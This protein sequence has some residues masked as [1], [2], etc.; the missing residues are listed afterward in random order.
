MVTTSIY[1]TEQTVLPWAQFSSQIREYLPYIND[2]IPIYFAH[3]FVDESIPLKVP[4]LDSPSL[5]LNRDLL[6]LFYLH[7]H[8]FQ[9]YPSLNLLYSSQKQGKKFQPLA[10]ALKS[11]FLDFENTLNRKYRSSWSYTD[12]DGVVKSKCAKKSDRSLFKGGM[13]R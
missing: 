4:K 13:E 10:F 6:G 5:M 2:I 12:I 7:N 9:Q 8:Y 3:K 11:K 1:K